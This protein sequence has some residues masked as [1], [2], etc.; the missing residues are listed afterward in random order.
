M[1]MRTKSDNRR[2]GMN[3]MSQLTVTNA[4]AQI[5]YD[6]SIEAQGQPAQG[7][8]L[9]HAGF[10]AAMK[11]MVDAISKCGK[12]VARACVSANIEKT[13]GYSAG[14]GAPVTFGPGVRTSTPGGG[15]LKIDFAAKQFV[16]VK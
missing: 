11:V 5:F 16:P 2:R 13:K 4:N 8:P 10:F 9:H 1:R 7:Q 3:T 6:D 14:V 15:L 12:D